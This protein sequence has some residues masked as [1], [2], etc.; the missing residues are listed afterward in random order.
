LLAQAHPESADFGVRKK[1]GMEMLNDEFFGL[2]AIAF[3]WIRLLHFSG[4]TDA[5][6]WI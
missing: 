4:L 2:A 5:F 6:P 1:A 3:L